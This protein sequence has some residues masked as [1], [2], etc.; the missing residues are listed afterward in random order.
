VAAV[1]SEESWTVEAA[2][3]L[4]E[5]SPEPVGSKTVWAIG[6]QRIIPNV[7]LQSW[8]RPASVA[9]SPEGCGYLI[10]D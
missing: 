8:T 9:G 4:A 10:F 5:L 2:I 7:G 1:Q 6:L 3:P